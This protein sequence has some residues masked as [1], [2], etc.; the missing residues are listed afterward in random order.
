MLA[1]AEGGR[2]NLD[3]CDFENTKDQVCFDFLILFTT[4]SVE[5]IQILTRQQT[6]LPR[7]A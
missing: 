1:R 6:V 5:H 2:S 7:V 3:I 4:G